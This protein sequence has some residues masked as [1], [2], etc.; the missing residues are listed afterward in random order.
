MCAYVGAY[1]VLVLASTSG[2]AQGIGD[3][4]LAPQLMAGYADLSLTKTVSDPEPAIGAQV[5]F[6]IT[7]ANAGPNAAQRVTVRDRLPTGY[8]YVSHS[9]TR[10]TYTRDTGLWSAFAVAKQ[11]SATLKIVATAL[12]DGNHTNIAEVTASSAPDPDSTPGNANVAEDDYA[13]VWAPPRVAERPNLVVLMVDDLDA[14]SLDDLLAAHLLPNLQSQIID[15]GIDLS[16]AYVSTPLCCP[17]RA[18]FLTGQYAHNTGIV[19]NKVPI[20]GIGIERAVGRFDDSVTIATRLQSLGYTTAHVG[21]YLNGYGSDATL[22]S[23]SPAFDPHYVPPGWSH[24]R[25]TV[26]YSTYCVYN[27]TINADGALTDY[28]LPP[29]VTSD[30][31]LYQTN[32]LAGLAEAF[33][34][35][36][37]DDAAPF[38]LEVMPLAPHAEHCSYDG[39]SPDDDGF[40]L[41]IRP[42]PLDANAVVPAY[43]PGPAYNEDLADKPAWMSVFPPLTADDLTNVSEQYQQRLRAL[44]SVDRLIGRLTAALGSSLDNTVIVFTSDNGWLYGEHRMSGKVYGYSGAARVPLY[45]VAP[46]IQAGTRSNLVLNNDLAPTLVDLASPGYAD[47]AF[48]GRSI[49]PL[50]GNPQPPGWEDRSQ[51]LIEFG[52]SEM[53]DAEHRTYAALRSRDQ[54]YIETRDS[55]Y[56]QSQQPLIGLELYDLAADPNE[57][58]S[59]MHHPENGRDAVLAPRLDQLSSCAG[60][61]CRSYEDTPIAP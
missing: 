20:P 51:F 14:R 48:D 45:I 32:M 37:R 9:A 1:A 33:V 53:S 27:Y 24:W 56:F 58:T 39:Y 6:R 19:N 44:L 30:S 18:T 43:V 2:A 4:A 59:L 12:Q 13:K 49:V 52:R 40:D 35:S 50:L 8:A 42:D 11:G 15:R 60:A 21:K 26:D 61:S 23:A 10:G 29:G 5:T 36:H 57:M 28:R 22:A 38:Y 7:V 46:G 17:S 47:A 31:A 16:E 54:L 3:P 34:Q 41:R 55:V 25:A